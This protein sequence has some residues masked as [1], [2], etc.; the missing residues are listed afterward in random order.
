[1]A[2]TAAS[3]E[4]LKRL[5]PLR[6]EAVVASSSMLLFELNFIQAGKVSDG[7]QRHREGIGWHRGRIGVA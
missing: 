4:E 2:A 1:M 5:L 6:T 3:L 7:Q